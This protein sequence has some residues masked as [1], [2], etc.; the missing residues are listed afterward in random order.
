MA[1]NSNAIEGSTLTLADT[2]VIYEGE[3]VAGKP[4]REQIAAKGIFEGSAFL[5]DALASGT[6]FD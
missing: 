2:E 5:D 1:Y 3:F 6:S 4:G